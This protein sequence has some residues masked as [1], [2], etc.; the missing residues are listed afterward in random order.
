MVLQL[1]RTMDFKAI[2]VTIDGQLEDESEIPFP[3][4][5]LFAS[6]PHIYKLWNPKL[7][8]IDEYY[9]TNS[10]DKP[11]ISQFEKE[12]HPT[13]KYRKLKRLTL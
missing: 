3:A 9:T 10:R 8:S 1:Y 2:S 7:Q 5:T 6:F 4:V 12:E 11:N 13:S